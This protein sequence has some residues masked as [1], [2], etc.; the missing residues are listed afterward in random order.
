MK[1]LVVNGYYNSKQITK[2]TIFG[3]GRLA[4]MAVHSLRKILPSKEACLRQTSTS[5]PGVFVG[6]KYFA[7]MND[8][9]SS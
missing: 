7:K 4:Q 9:I 1:T 5:T 2:T 8:K 6:L 3:R